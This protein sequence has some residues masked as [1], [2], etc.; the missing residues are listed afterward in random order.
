MTQKLT[1]LICLGGTIVVAF[2]VYVIYSV[3]NGVPIA[4]VL[5]LRRRVVQHPEDANM[6]DYQ[7]QFE[8]RYSV[9]SSRHPSRHQS[10]TIANRRQMNM[11]TL[12]RLHET[13][14]E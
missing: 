1:S 7:I 14:A 10:M 3:W 13:L 8:Q 5:K 6:T 12:V 11:P 4:D 2:V 9:H